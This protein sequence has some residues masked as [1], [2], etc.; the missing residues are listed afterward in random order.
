MHSPLVLF[1]FDP[2]HHPAELLADLFERVIPLSATDGL[3]S[4]M[5]KPANNF[6][7][8]E[9]MTEESNAFGLPRTGSRLRRAQ[10]MALSNSGRFQ[11]GDRYIV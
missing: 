3:D 7:R 6:Q 1:G 10:K 9:L 11:S 5:Q 8:S 2:S 4:G